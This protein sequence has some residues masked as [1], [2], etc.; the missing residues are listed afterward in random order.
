MRRAIV[1][2]VALMVAGLAAVA[3]P[4]AA[5]AG[6]PALTVIKNHTG[7]FT[8]GSTATF[9]LGLSSAPSCCDS[10][11][12][13]FTITDTLPAGLTF[14]SGGNGT[15]TCPAPAGQTVTCTTT[16]NITAGSQSTFPLVVNVLPTAFPSVTNSATASDSCACGFTYSNNP[17]SD[18]ATVVLATPPAYTKEPGNGTG[19][20]TVVTSFL[21]TGLAQTVATTDGTKSVTLA[22]PAAGLPAGTQV[23][24]YRGSP[25][26]LQA[27]LPTGATYVDGYA[28]GWNLSGRTFSATSAITMTVKDPAVTAA[29]VIYVT[30]G[31]ALAT[32]TATV[33]AGQ[34]V[35]T[36]TV[37]P[38]FVAAGAIPVPVTG[39]AAGGL[40]AVVLLMAGAVLVGFGIA[41]R[42]ARIA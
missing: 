8:V 31:S 22:L 37:D 16:T 1:V 4:R 35:V 19:F 23:T 15:W 9:T 6:N 7:A 13:T 28:V 34:Y 2:V 5:L 25:A 10:G 17:A 40:V 24:L 20:P 12:V 33:T 18:M 30:A 14:S 39:A 29:T 41:R 36:F 42:R 26:P 21:A 11:S 32:T 3:S 38:G 27:D